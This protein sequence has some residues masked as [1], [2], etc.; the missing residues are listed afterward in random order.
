MA[1]WLSQWFP[2]LA[3]VIGITTNQAIYFAV[4]AGFVLVFLLV[5]L[6]VMQLYPAT[7]V[8]ID[9]GSRMVTID[10]A[11]PFSRRRVFEIPFAEIDRFELD[12]RRIGRLSAIY[13][14]LIVFWNGK[15]HYLCS[16]SRHHWNKDLL[17]RL[18]EA[19]GIETSEVRA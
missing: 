16:I 15:G 18:G 11:G 3:I 10:H 14:K 4:A 6:T 9:P 1:T 2:L 12:H 17:K 13:P 7:K 19:T 8:L 5:D